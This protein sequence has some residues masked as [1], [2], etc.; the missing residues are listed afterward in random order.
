MLWFV[1]ASAQNNDFIS[2]VAENK[3]NIN[4]YADF[5]LQYFGEKP[6]SDDYGSQS[7]EIISIRNN[8][9]CVL[10]KYEIYDD[11]GNHETDLI[12]FNKKGEQI[13]K[14]KFNFSEGNE[15]ETRSLNCEISQNDLIHCIFNE[16]LGNLRAITDEN[17]EIISYEY[18]T[19]RDTTYQIN[20]VITV[21]GEIL[22][23]EDI[24]DTIKD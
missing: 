22:G 3:N 12:T 23:E 6:Y 1:N 21:D 17:D 8:F 15:F 24:D 19:V 20:Y 4:D 5:C 18:Y 10:S 7:Y 11:L 9:V 13:D 14:L 2:F 16:N